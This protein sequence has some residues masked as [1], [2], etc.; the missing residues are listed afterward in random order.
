MQKGNMNWF[1]QFLKWI[2]SLFKK[3][4]KA[5]LGIG[6]SHV[7]LLFFSRDGLT[8]S[9]DF[10]MNRFFDAI[11]HASFKIKTTWLRLMMNHKLRWTDG[12][13]YGQ[14]FCPYN[15]FNDMN[16]GWNQTWFDKVEEFT[17]KC[18]NRKITVGFSLIDAN[19]I[20][21]GP[22]PLDWFQTNVP[23]PMEM[24]F[25]KFLSTMGKWNDKDE[26]FPKY[27]FILEPT[28]E[29]F[30]HSV[31]PGIVWMHNAVDL[32]KLLTSGKIQI[33]A[34]WN[35]CPVNAD[36]K[37]VHSGIGDGVA[38]TVMNESCID[39]EWGGGASQENYYKAYS[40]WIPRGVKVIDSD[41]DDALQP[42]PWAANQM[43]ALGQCHE[44]KLF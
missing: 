40:V 17:K 6:I 23:Q 38:G 42:S 27:K 43:G 37:V 32:L 35:R 19:H 25:R 13:I 18:N 24:Y 21:K 34:W 31:L 12:Y 15:V 5:E 20:D 44:E 16:S 9:I 22:Y 28:N 36:F 11:D 3:D 10:E 1:K 14:R 7:F 2:E 4:W 29:Q 41:W 39:N 8:G 26:Y 30:G 33:G